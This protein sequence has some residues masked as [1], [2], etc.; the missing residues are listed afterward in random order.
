MF[1]SHSNK[2]FNNKSTHSINK[3]FPTIKRKT[4]TKTKNDCR[5]PSR[6]KTNRKVFFNE[7]V[8]ICKR[9]FE[10]L[11]KK[12]L[13]ESEEQVNPTPQPFQCSIQFQLQRFVAKQQII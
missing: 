10:I 3:S 5:V 9:K 7:I 13:N 4:K 8:F 6:I 2:F 11:D 12:S 1:N